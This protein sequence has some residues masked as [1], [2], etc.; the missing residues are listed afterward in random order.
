MRLVLHIGTEKTGSTAIQ[1]HLGLNAEQLAEVGI[2]RCDTGG[3][4][5]Q[6][7]LA[8]AF[9]DDDR[10]DE[11]LRLHGYVDPGA[12]AEWRDALLASLAAEVA[13]AREYADVFVIS[14]EHFHSRLLSQASVSRL[15]AAITGEFTGCRVIAYLRR[16]DE[17][18]LSFYSQK[19][20]AGYVP[21]T[22]LPMAGVAGKTLPPYFDFES[23]LRRW[24]VAFGD[25][26]VEPVV[27]PG[28]N[29][30]SGDVVDDFFARLGVAFALER[31]PG[32]I[33][34]A[35]SVAAQDALLAFNGQAGRDAAD[36]EFHRVTRRKLLAYLE[37]HGVGAGRLPL[38]D[39]ALA[40]YAAFRASNQRVA[41]RWFDG[42]A[43]F[44]EDFSA[45]PEQAQPADW[46]TVATLFAGFAA[47]QSAAEC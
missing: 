18:A 30:P 31:A 15:A 16:Q 28:G 24:A 47:S 35:L 11:Y 27:Y 4:G 17:M 36:R 22:I 7:A 14:S 8:S 43:M 23:L 2:A 9:M 5:N 37:R 44:S 10:A 6:R 19:L 26:T 25:D 20:R 1:Q 12:R 45:Y 40:F 46:E 33:N 3:S 32:A 42:G 29:A 41:E 13:A 39:E 21:P 38:R 34:P